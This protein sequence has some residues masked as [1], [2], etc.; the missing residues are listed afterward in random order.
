[1]ENTTQ[2]RLDKLV[3][4]LMKEGKK[5]VAKKILENTLKEIKSA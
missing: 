4:Y 2:Q 5:S 1:M 3:N